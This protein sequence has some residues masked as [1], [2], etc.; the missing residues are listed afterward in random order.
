MAD[1]RITEL[2]ELTTLVN[3]DELLVSDTS[4]TETKKIT[5]GNFKTNV[6]GSAHTVQNN[7]IG[8][9]QRT[10]LNF[11]GTNVIQTDDSSITK[12]AITLSENLQPE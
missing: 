1:K 7:G 10:N 11:D 4:A 2:N 12:S 3:A 6:V 8:L 5:V 9:T